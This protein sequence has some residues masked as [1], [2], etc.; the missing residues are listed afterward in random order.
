MEAAVTSLFKR[1]DRKKFELD[2]EEELRF[3]FELLRQEYIQQGMSPAAATDA[4]LKR[5]G[6][7]ERIKSQCVEISRRSQPIIRALKTFLIL[8][9]LAGVLMRV[10]SSVPQFRQ[11]ADTLMAVAALSRLLLYA[12]G[13][14]PSN[15]LPKSE[16]VSPSLFNDGSQRPFA[17]NHAGKRTPIERVISDE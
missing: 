7:L 3:H 4:A 8:V 16:T 9:F 11:I 2:I 10:F 6:D 14:S 1:F 12:R 15:F 13:L 5:F 17:A